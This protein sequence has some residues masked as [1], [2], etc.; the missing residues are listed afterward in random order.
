MGKNFKQILHKGRYTDSHAHKN[1]FNII[2]LQE[3]VN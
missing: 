3:N 2:S 1:V